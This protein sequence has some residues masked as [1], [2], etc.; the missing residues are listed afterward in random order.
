LTESVCKFFDDCF[1]FQEINL[2]P[3]FLNR[4]DA[5]SHRAQNANTFTRATA[6]C[7]AFGHSALISSPSGLGGLGGALAVSSD[8]G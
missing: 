4:Q 3:K 8:H 1:I 2:N 5:K 7:V 6:P